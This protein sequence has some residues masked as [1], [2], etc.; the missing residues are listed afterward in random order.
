MTKRQKNKNPTINI[1]SAESNQTTSLSSLDSPTD[2][3][4]SPEA[5][6]ILELF[7][8]QVRTSL[9][10]F[11]QVQQEVNKLLTKQQPY[12]QHQE[13]FYFD[14]EGD[15]SFFDI[16]LETKHQLHQ[17]ARSNSLIEMLPVQ[18]AGETTNTNT[19]TSHISREC[20]GVDPMNPCPI[21]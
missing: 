9:N 10:A 19:E 16:D 6:D 2:D 18:I 21:L 14:R 8:K 11:D 20:C 4:L 5:R 7:K 15:E 17:L 1:P 3:E 12:T 13:L